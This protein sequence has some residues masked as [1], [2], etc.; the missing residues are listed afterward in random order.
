MSLPS[1]AFAPSILAASGF[2]Y[3]LQQ[4][5]FP[6]KI[7]L[8]LLFMLS[9]LSWA[10]MVSKAVSFHRMRRADLDFNR[11][12][13][14]AG[15]PMQLFERNYS[16]E[17]SM[18][19]LVY[20]HGAHEA[21]FQMLGSPERDA[22]FETRLRSAEGMAPGQLNAVREAFKRGEDAAAAR[23]R[24]GL[25][26]LSAAAAGAPFLGLLGM[27]WILMKTFSGGSAAA[28][29]LAGVSPG[30]A[31]GL[32]MMVV[33]LLVATPAIFGQILITARGRERLRELGEFR[34]EAFRLMARFYATGELETEAEAETALETAPAARKNAPEDF[35]AAGFTGEAETAPESVFE[36]D[37]EDADVALETGMTGFVEDESVREEPG[38]IQGEMPLSE[39]ES[40]FEAI[41]GFVEPEPEAAS[42]ASL[43]SPVEVE[44][45]LEPAPEKPRRSAFKTPF[46][47]PEI[48]PIA[49]QTAG[50][51][52][53]GTA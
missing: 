30:I 37:G 16:D 26:I 29:G 22:T 17:L 48:N 53:N 4:P 6:G 41:E 20:E 32:A 24:L 15:Q 11:R 3:A 8:W 2:D 52:A 5:L 50:L 45:P 18:R 38:M 19:W 14:A 36:I 7:L 47:E 40:P 34:D 49:Q 46:S 10:V 42:T 21:A 27:V 9:L 1:L 25:P 13:R 31:G 28:E 44:V 12:F 39:F 33:A 23:I 51:L 43:S 35:E